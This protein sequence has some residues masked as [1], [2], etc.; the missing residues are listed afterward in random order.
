MKGVLIDLDGVVYQN[1]TLIA[2]ADRAI[3]WLEQERIP[4]LFLTN[5]TSRPRSALLTRLSAM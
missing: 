4:H 1:D 5:T 2:G 3:A